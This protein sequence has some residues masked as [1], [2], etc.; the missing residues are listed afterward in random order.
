[1]P[2]LISYSSSF[3]TVNPIRSCCVLS[4]GH[5]LQTWCLVAVSLHQFRGPLRSTAPLS[6]TAAASRRLPR[7]Y[8]TGRGRLNLYTGLSSVQWPHLCA[9]DHV[10][11]PCQ[12][13]A[14]C[15]GS[16]GD[17]SKS[18]LFGTVARSDRTLNLVIGW[19][20]LVGTA[21]H[22]DCDVTLFSAT[23]GEVDTMQHRGYTREVK[24]AQPDFS[25]GFVGVSPL[26]PRGLLGCSGGWGYE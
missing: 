8:Q 17:I 1:M 15:G 9:A 2:R 22:P 14:P 3:R 6:P 19:T 23:S 24:Q 21:T 26:V 4:G 16:W 18:T 13:N 11:T 10:N 12:T 20:D 5:F 7:L 25:E